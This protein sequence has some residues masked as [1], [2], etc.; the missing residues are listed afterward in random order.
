VSERNRELVS[1]GSWVCLMLALNVEAFQ[2][3]KFSIDLPS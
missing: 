2:I 3:L 1:G